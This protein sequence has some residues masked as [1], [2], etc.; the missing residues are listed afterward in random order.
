MVAICNKTSNTDY[1]DND[2]DKLLP[3]VDFVKSDTSYMKNENDNNETCLNKVAQKITSTVV[4]GSLFSILL[5]GALFV[6]ASAMTLIT[7]LCVCGINGI[8]YLYNLYRVFKN[9]FNAM[10]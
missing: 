2:K 7:L 5:F 3:N 6:L 4:T 10:W 8:M 9:T 1:N